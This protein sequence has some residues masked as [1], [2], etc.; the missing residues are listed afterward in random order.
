M[1]KSKLPKL[2]LSLEEKQMNFLQA[3][4]DITGISKSAQIRM[5][6]V[7]EMNKTKEKKQNG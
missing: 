7:K 4:R 6:I 5:L 3:Q 2:L 1:R